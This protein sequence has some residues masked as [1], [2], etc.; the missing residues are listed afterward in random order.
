[1][2]VSKLQIEKLTENK[3]RIILNLDDLKENNIEPIDVVCVNINDYDLKNDVSAISLIIK[4]CH[5]PL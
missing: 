3:I 1:M 4:S 5:L 2:E